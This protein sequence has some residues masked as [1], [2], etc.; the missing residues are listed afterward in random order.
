MNPLTFRKGNSAI[1]YDADTVPHPEAVP[2]H[3]REASES[4]PVVGAGR[5]GAWRVRVDGM[6]GALRQYRRGGMVR[7]FLRTSYLWTGLER[8]RAFCEWRL[9]ARLHADG[10]PV[11]RPLAARVVRTAFW[12]R[13][14]ILTEWLSATHSLVSRLKDAE[15]EPALWRRIGAVLRRFH[16]AGAWHADLNAHN[17]LIDDGGRVFLID[18]DRG[19]LLAPDGAWTRSNLARLK[20]SLE[21]VH[22]TGEALYYTPD[23]W[24]QLLDGYA[25]GE[26]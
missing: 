25:N 4:E 2:F 15:L 17:I 10:L 20:R 3:H 7:L 18:F 22:A 11:P 23:G 12:Y 1:L 14:E 24:N 19:T 26:R 6:V 9:T 5:G 21:K 16:R 8:T 13:A